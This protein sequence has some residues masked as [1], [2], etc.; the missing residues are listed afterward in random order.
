M[1]WSSAL[2]TAEPRAHVVQFYGDDDRFFIRN[3]TRYL[4]EGLKR[5]Q[6]LLVVATPAHTEA[7]VL[8][9]TSSQTPV[10]SAVERGGIVLLDA[11]ATLDRIMAGGAPDPDRF[12]AVVG[13]ALHRAAAAGGHGRVRA[14]GE[15]VGLLW[16]AGQVAAAIRLEEFWNELIARENFS[17]F[18][19]YPID[20]FG[21]EFQRPEVDAVL[22]AHSC[23]VP[24]DR[25]FER[26]IDAALGDVLGPA[27]DSVRLLLRS[28]FQSWEAMPRVELTAQWLRRNLPEQAGA[29]LERARQIGGE[30]LARPRPA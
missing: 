21:P 11:Q 25:A 19:G 5:R 3:V 16:A 14:Y 20:V 29:V 22:C 17:L 15:M 13:D 12:R 30:L 6:G 7:F 2:E 26:A 18:C 4:S 27:A 28:A 10:H 9:L 1:A 24:A 23:L 8:H